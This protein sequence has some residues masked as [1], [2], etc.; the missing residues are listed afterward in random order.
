MEFWQA[1]KPITFPFN[2]AR[3]LAIRVKKYF[4]KHAPSRA[5]IY[6][7]FSIK[8]IELICFFFFFLKSLLHILNPS[9]VVLPKRNHIALTIPPV[10]EFL[11]MIHLALVHRTKEPFS[12]DPLQYGLLKQNQH[13]K[14]FGCLLKPIPELKVI[15]FKCRWR[16]N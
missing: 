1:S 9:F 4:R 15:I 11:K 12:S 13:F 16:N 7:G 5:H 6:N 8:N 3:L 14:I 10:W 2:L